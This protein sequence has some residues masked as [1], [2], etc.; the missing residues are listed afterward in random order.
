[1]EKRWWTS[2]FKPFWSLF[3]KSSCPLCQRTARGGFCQYCQKQIWQCQFTN[4]SQLWQ[5]E[6]PI[7]VWGE[8]RGA[9]KR[10]IAAFKYD[11]K[12]EIGKP[13]GQW[14]AQ[15]WLNYPELAIDK[16]TVVPI[17]LHATKLKKRG[18]NQAEILAENFCELT[19]LPLQRQGL[20]RVKDTK[21]LFDLSRKQR[22]DEMKEALILGKGF[23]RRHPPGGVLL[24]DDIYTSG[25]TVKSA[26]EALKREGIKVYGVVAIATTNNG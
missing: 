13:L 24:V 26:T 6:M 3:L 11:N 14:L 21:P 4:N 15:A 1:M 2:Y 12:P 17:P 20:E 22:Q 25:T 8:Y 23:R 5:G 7:F 16:L 10:A 18:F 19:G 9:L